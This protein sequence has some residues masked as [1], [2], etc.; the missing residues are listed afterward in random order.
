[1][2]TLRLNET[3]EPGLRSWVDSANVPG[4]DFPI[5][6]LPFGVFRRTG[7]TQSF[8]GGVAIGDYILDL[9]AAHDAGLF[10]GLAAQAAL[11]AREPQLN[12]LMAAGALARVAAWLE[13]A[14]RAAIHAAGA[15]RGRVHVAGPDR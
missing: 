6:N 14:R 1:M 15:A 7:S 11:V 5:Q 9:G 8:R 3:H 4:H 13:R 2:S 10:E 12:A